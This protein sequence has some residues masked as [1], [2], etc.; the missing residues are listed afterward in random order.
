MSSK[1]KLLPHHESAGLR[2]RGEILLPLPIPGTMSNKGLIKKAGKYR[3][4]FLEG[5]TL[6]DFTKM[7]PALAICIT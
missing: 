1:G 7:F 2:Q 4:V 3:V 6:I 5:I